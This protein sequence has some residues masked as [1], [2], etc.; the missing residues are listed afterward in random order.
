MLSNIEYLKPEVQ[1]HMTELLR[2]HPYHSEIN[3]ENSAENWSEGAEG[4]GRS[5]TSSRSS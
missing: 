2:Y 4:G 3:E 5:T 1:K